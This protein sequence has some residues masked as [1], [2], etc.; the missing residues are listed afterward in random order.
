[1]YLP[2]WLPHR[3]RTL[4]RRQTRTRLF[5]E[6][7]ENRVVPTIV[8]QPQFGA[9]TATYNGGPTLTDAPVELIFWG[10]YWNNVPAGKPTAAQLTT[11][12]TNE[13]NSPIYNGLSQYN[14]GPAHV[15]QSWVA[16]EDA[17]PSSGFTDDQLRQVITDAINDPRSPLLAPSD[18]AA[19]DGGHAPIY[20]VVTPPNLTSSSVPDAGGFHNDYNGN[21]YAGNEN[22]IY[23][24]SANLGGPGGIVSYLSAQDFVTVVASHETGESLTDPQPLTGWT[25]TPG[26]TWFG[27]TGNEIYDQEPAAIYDYRLNGSLVQAMWDQAAGAYTVSDG[28][29][30]EF[31]LVPQYGGGFYPNG[32]FGSVLDLYANQLFLNSSSNLP[33]NDSVTINTTAN[34]GVTVNMNG[35]V[36]TFDPGAITAINVFTGN[37]TN[38]VNILGTPQDV[39]TDIVG[40]GTDTLNLG[41]NGSTQGIQGDVYIENPPAF[42]T[43]NINDSA[44]PTSRTVGIQNFAG[45]PPD[46]QHSNAPWGQITGLLGPKSSTASILFEY[47]DTR[48]VNINTGIGA[49]TINVGATG[50]TTNLVTHTSANIFVSL[51]NASQPSILGTLNIENPP[52]FNTIQIKDPVDNTARTF[53]LSTLGPNPADSQGNS[54]E[55][56]Q[57]LMSGD[58]PIDYEYADTK[59]VTLDT[60]TA[61]GNVVNVRATGAPVTINSGGPDAL[62][63]GDS[64]NH[65][66][67]IQGALT[68]NGKPGSNT[69]LVLSDQGTTTNQVYELSATQVQRLTQANNTY[70]PNIAPIAYS[71]IAN[72]ALHA[73]NGGS[74]TLFIYSTSAGTTTNVYGGSDNS[75]ATFT[76]DEFVVA[77]VGATLDAVLGA[78]NLY[79][80]TAS[81]KGES[82]VIQNDSLT[83]SNRTY[84]LTAGSTPNSG[85]LNRSGIAPITFAGMVEDILYTSENTSAVV[86]VQSNA[87]NIDT[88]IAADGPGDQVNVGSL[89]PALGGTVANVNGTVEVTGTGPATLTVDDSGDTTAK[90]VATGQVSG[91]LYSITGLSQGTIEYTSGSVQ[92]LT[93]DAPNTGVENSIDVNGTPTGTALNVH[94]GFGNIIVLSVPDIGGPL[95]VALG[96][97]NTTYWFDGPATDNNRVYTINSTSVTRTGGFVTN[98]VYPTGFASESFALYTGN[99]FTDT[100]D[101]QSSLAHTGW[102]LDGAPFNPNV[103]N[104]GDPVKGLASVKG[105]IHVNTEA[106]PGSPDVETVNL[107]DQPDINSQTFTFNFDP[108]QGLNNVSWDGGGFLA[109]N[110]TP[111][112]LAN[113]VING[114]SGNTIFQVKTLPAT[115]T[116]ITLNGG[117]GVNT[118]DY[119][120]YVGDIAVDLPLGVA[121]GFS[122]GIS[123]IENVTGGQGNDLI[124]GDANANVLIGG[125]GRNL[126]IGGAGADQ[127]TGGG[128]DNLLIGG[129]T[130]YDENLTALDA[131]FAEWT[132]SDSLATRMRDIRFGGGLNGSYYLN[133]VATKKRPATVFGN[134]NDSL[135]DGTGLSWFFV[136]SPKDI[137]K[138]S[139][140]SNPNDVVTHIP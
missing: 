52:A 22:I 4:V 34:G 36:A 58:A 71:N 111:P 44:D 98:I 134:P 89:A 139:G 29:I 48:S 37:G 32:F 43:I 15:D 30:Q 102:F 86:N 115:S 63:V 68:V 96:E 19:S 35:E 24:W 130:A 27:P 95:T 105:E 128:G 125:T 55:W 64:S 84:T 117:S 39:P 78:L 20:F 11:A 69:T 76:V 50:A 41:N 79:G 127:I 62:N 2:M 133:P 108:N 99:P 33:G 119:S 26:A 121:T 45:T 60:G 42:T 103:F 73:G 94:A 70:V 46:S 120:R 10:S 61:A 126:I 12:I 118:L 6:R 112:P 77:S 138:G 49:S 3:G 124:V 97:D 107:N 57:V 21:T 87:S 85:A 109:Y 110:N 101:V 104:I 17:D 82:Y 91:N 14:A 72:L 28:T 18:V 51:T 90:T 116:A 93:I 75:Q 129:T 113:L 13:F 16:T 83:S 66:D 65:L 81:P 59:S 54:D 80:Q 132:S 123:K 74:N 31:D 5:L 40:G 23:G 53:T 100:I 92:S 135:F 88:V 106:E 1:M 8:F 47:I 140:P 122:G 67:G 114:G 136:N 131:L 137:N 38:T 56:G 9:E 25:T 7:L